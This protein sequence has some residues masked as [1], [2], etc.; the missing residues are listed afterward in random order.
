MCS[1][2]SMARSRGGAREGQ[3]RVPTGRFSS[4]PR[5]AP[6]RRR[7]RLVFSLF[8]RAEFRTMRIPRTSP[9]LLCNL[10]YVL[11][12]ESDR[13]LHRKN[14]A[15]YRNVLAA[16]PRKELQLFSGGI[17]EALCNTRH[18]WARVHVQHCARL[19]ASELALDATLAWPWNPD[20]SCFEPLTAYIPISE[21]GSMQGAVVVRRDNRSKPVL[22]WVWIVPSMRSKGVFSRVWDTLSER[23]GEFLIE[24]PYSRE[25]ERFLLHRGVGEERRVGAQYTLGCG[26]IRFV[27]GR[28]EPCDRT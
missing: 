24:G 9:C 28:I 27:E 12:L 14:C 26:R 20:Y 6:R 18:R 23:C 13:K 17:F 22:V 2:W 15:S 8:S 25:M 10:H 11:E 19:L 21:E 5:R 7:Q 4:T 3:G 1:R 16:K